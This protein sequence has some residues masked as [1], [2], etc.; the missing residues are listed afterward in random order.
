MGLFLIEGHWP[1]IL[2]QNSKGACKMCV[3]CMCTVYDVPFFPLRLKFVPEW[4]EICTRL[5]GNFSQ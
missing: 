2:P 5:A 4:P 3:L 1:E